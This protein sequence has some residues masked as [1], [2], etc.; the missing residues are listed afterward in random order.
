MRDAQAESERLRRELAD[1]RERLQY[2]VD[3]LKTFGTDVDT[4]YAQCCTCFRFKEP[5][6]KLCWIDMPKTLQL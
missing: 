3:A 1:E 4:R 5:L 6:S 2:E